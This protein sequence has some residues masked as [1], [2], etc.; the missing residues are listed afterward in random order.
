[1]S[2]PKKSKD[3]PTISQ[4][5]D[6]VHRLSVEEQEQLLERLAL[7]R[8]KRDVQ[9]GIDELDRGEFVDGEQLLEE[10]RVSAEDRLKT[11]H[12]RKSYGRP[13]NPE[14][15]LKLLQH[16]LD[17]DERSDDTSDWEDLK[18]SLDSHRS[19]GNK[20]FSDD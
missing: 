12:K 3:K 17:T 8:L 11:T 10:L 5:L 20:L 6:M 13:G 18:K 14:K 4:I 19:P 9:L 15:A 7:E 16:W 1:M 2:K